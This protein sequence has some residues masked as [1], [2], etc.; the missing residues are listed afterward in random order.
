MDEGYESMRDDYMDYRMS[1][2]GGGSGEGGCGCIFLG[3][4]I[5]FAIAL[6]L[7]LFG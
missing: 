4:A 2:E 7:Q 1:S 5:F 6:I 3:I